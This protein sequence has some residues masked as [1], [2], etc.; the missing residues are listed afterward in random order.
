[1]WFASATVLLWLQ[2]VVE[3]SK[4]GEIRTTNTDSVEDLRGWRGWGGEGVLQLWG[5]GS[6]TAHIRGR[7]GKEG[8]MAEATTVFVFISQHL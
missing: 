4:K 1:M 5:S 7:E 6:G 2:Q 8:K 3:Q